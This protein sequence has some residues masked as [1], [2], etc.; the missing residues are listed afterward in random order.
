MEV[1]KISSISGFASRLAQQFDDS[2]VASIQ[3]Y[4]ARSRQADK[5]DETTVKYFLQDL[6]NGL[7][8]VNNAIAAVSVKLAESDLNFDQAEAVAALELFPVFVAERKIKGTADERNYFVQS[9]KNVLKYKEEKLYWKSVLEYLKGVGRNLDATHTD[10]RTCN[11]ISN[12][13]QGKILGG[14]IDT[15]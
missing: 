12:I 10:A 13:P 15:W 5:I 14:N 2:A 7:N 6:V 8:E 1:Q 9:D 4:I 11:K 3:G